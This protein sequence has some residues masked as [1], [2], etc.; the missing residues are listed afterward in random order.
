MGAIV[1]AFDARREVKEQV[2][3]LGAEFIE[4]DSDEEGSGVGGYAKTM[5]KEFIEAE[6]ALFRRQ[7]QE[8]DIIITTALVPGEP[9]PKLI[10]ADMV[11]KLRDGSVIVDLA[12]EQG[13]N[14]ELTEPGKVVVKHGVTIIGYTDFPSR[15]APQSSSLYATNLRHLLTDSRR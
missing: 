1:R 7:A 2:E 14:C 10:L 13:G 9:A 8:V 4:V 3:S 11:E 15:L 6:M 5:S 12:S